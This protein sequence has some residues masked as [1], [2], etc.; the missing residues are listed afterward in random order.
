MKNY[1]RKSLNIKLKAIPVRP[2]LFTLGL[3]FFIPIIFLKISYGQQLK[4]FII[5]SIG[6]EVPLKNKPKNQIHKQ[7]DQPIDDEEFPKKNYFINM[8]SNQGLK[9]G[10]K[11]NIYRHHSELDPYQ[12]QMRFDFKIK[13]GQLEVIHTEKTTSITKLKNFLQE[14]SDIQLEIDAPII[15]DIVEIDLLATSKPV[16]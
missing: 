8:G 13:V 10:T 9:K 4:N 6:Q 1:L 11:L 14:D 16:N 2:I 5:Y 15:G 7:D 12:N 3:V